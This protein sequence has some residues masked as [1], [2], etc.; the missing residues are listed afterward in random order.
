MAHW[1]LGLLNHY[2]GD[3]EEAIS[4][5]E[6]SQA[7][8]RQHRNS[9]GDLEAGAALML[10]IVEVGRSNHVAADTMLAESLKLARAPGPTFGPLVT[11]HRGR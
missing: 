5:L 7:I 2:L 10:G 8:A 1:L 6:Q 11:Y 4:Q 3:H 9:I